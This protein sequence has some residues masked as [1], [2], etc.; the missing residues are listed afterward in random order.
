M[1]PKSWP[2]APVEWETR[3]RESFFVVLNQNHHYRRRRAPLQEKKSINTEASSQPT[4]PP[5]RPPGYPLL[6]VTNL[7][8]DF[9]DSLS[10]QL[11]DLPNAKTA[12][13]LPGVQLNHDIS[14]VGQGHFGGSALVL[15]LLPVKCILGNIFRVETQDTHTGIRVMNVTGSEALLE[16]ELLVVIGALERELEEGGRILI[17]FG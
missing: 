3:V 12:V 10:T 11:S 5:F 13:P 2:A 15:F 16:K 7:V 9:V 17:G 6:P 4:V 14:R 1:P 8:D